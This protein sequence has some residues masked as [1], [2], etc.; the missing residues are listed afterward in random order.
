MTITLIAFMS[1]LTTISLVV[2]LTRLNIKR[3]LG[4]R[5]VI[6]V[7]AT[8]CLPILLAGSFVS[9]MVALGAG[10]LLTLCLYALSLVIGCEK[11]SFKN[12]WSYYPPKMKRV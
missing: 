10:L 5:H 8:I 4:Y 11:W 1:L 12:G 6:D 7:A 3:V 9:A 2:F